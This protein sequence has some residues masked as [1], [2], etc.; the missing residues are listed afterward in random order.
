MKNNFTKFLLLIF[1]VIIFFNFAY[2]EEQFKFNITEIEIIENGNLIVGSKNGKAETDDGYEIFAEN[3]VYNK[4][5]NILNISGNVKFIN[6]N[7]NLIIFADKATYLKNDEIIFTE[8]NSKA[9]VENKYNFSS[10]DVI[11]NKNN[12]QI[13]SNNNTTVID[14]NGNI[15]KSSKFLY[16]LNTG[17]LKAKKVNIIT[18]IDKLKKDNYFFSEGI[19][20]LKKKSF[21]SKETKVKVHKNIFDNEEQDPRIYGASSSGDEKKTI[22]HKGIFTS[23][24][25]NDGCPPWSVYSE[26]ITHDKVKKDLIYK[27]A[28][29]KIYDIPVFYFPKFFHPDPSVKRRTGFLQPQLNRSKTLGSSIYAPYF[30]TLGHDKDYTFKPTIFE[31]KDG[32]SKVIL[33]NEFRKKSEFSTLTADFGLMKGYKS[34]T[35]NKKKSINHLFV[36][37]EKDLNL[38]DFLS[39]DF[40]LKIERVNNDTYLKVFQEN[41]FPS[42][43]MPKNKNVMETKLNYDLD[44]EDF[45]L[46]TGFQ[47]YESLGVQQSDRYQY[48]LPSYNYSRSLNFDNINGSVEFYSSGS[49]NL[50]DTNNLRTSITNDLNYKSSDYFTKYGLKNNFNL[51]FKNSNT[52]GKNDPTYSSSPTLDGMSILEVSSI[53]PLIK[54]NILSEEILTPK[55]SFRVNPGN[56]MK[57][58][59]SSGKNVSAHNIFEINRL[60]ISDSFEGGKS[61]TLGIDYKLDYENDFKL[62]SEDENNIK[63]K[64]F[65]FKLATV[66][67]DTEENEIPTSSTLD[68][69][70]SNLFGSIKTQLFHNVDFNYDFSVDND[71]KKFESHSINS[72][73]TVNNF[74]TEFDFLEQKNE[75]GSSHIISNKT[76][77]KLNENT[78]FSFATRRNKEIS[79][80]EYYDLAYEYKNDCLT[81]A[82]KYNRTFYQDDDFVPSEN[83][84]LSVTL[85]PLTTYERQLYERDKYGNE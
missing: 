79:L 21:L 39:S 19:F 40:N 33:Q 72:T 24:K 26:K 16:Q 51:Y 20:N 66:I 8:G 61:L 27:N 73:I 10:K 1:S 58:H 46:S 77:Y 28:I 67:R 85:I 9:V 31:N 54:K 65:E 76:S 23:C 53:F 38:D 3:F 4:L 32:K 36:E 44:H 5:T 71:F 6:K 50:K 22:I 84:F 57:D 18:Q 75:L 80:T 69:K 11:Y 42:P 25:M 13:S 48:V 30:V 60:G 34:S 56:N 17:L 59:S 12:E 7:E 68:K 81:A 70:N 52:I 63:D 37:Y 78:T 74:I 83:L 15:Y 14:D 29:L 55:I 82:L 2:A 45:N 41:L 49:N 62:T 35:T 64:F 43:V 47:I